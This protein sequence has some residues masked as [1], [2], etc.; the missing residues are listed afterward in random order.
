MLDL[1]FLAADWKTVK[2]SA[3]LLDYVYPYLH[4]NFAQKV[5]QVTLVYFELGYNIV[6]VTE[7]FVSLQTSV[8]VTQY[9]NVTVNSEEI[10]GTTAYLTP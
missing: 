1:E 4:D 7:Y 5:I 3:L 10:I 8:V 9:Y 6:K 2:S